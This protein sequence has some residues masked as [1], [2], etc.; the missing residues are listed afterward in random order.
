MTYDANGGTGSVDAQ[1]VVAG[2]AANLSDGT[3]LTA[4]ENKTFAGWATTNDAE[5]AD[6]ES[7]YTPTESI[8]L[9]AVWATV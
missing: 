5:E 1:I 3:G 9:Y 8:T 2:N 4:P 7:P 6:V